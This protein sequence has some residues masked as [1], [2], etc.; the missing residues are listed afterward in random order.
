MNVGVSVMTHSGQS[1]WQSGIG[2]NALHLA[3]LLRSLPFVERVVFINVGD[4]PALPADALGVGADIPMLTQREATDLIDVA[5]ELAGGLD[6]EWID[7]L[8]ALG[9]KVVFCC[10]GQPYVALA[11]P[12]VFGMEGFFSRADRCDEVWL[13]P[14]DRALAPMMEALHRCRCVEVPFLW[15]PD[16]VEARICDRGTA[17]PRFGYAGNGVR[18]L[19]IMEPNISVLKCCSIPMLICD[20]AYR[21]AGDAALDTLH[22][23]NSEHMAQRPTF[24]YLHRSLDMTKRGKTR[25][26]HRHDVVG[27]MA[28]NAD[29]VVSHQWCNDQN[30]L[31]LDLLHGGYPL[32]HNSPWLRGLGY[33]YPEFDIEAGAHALLTAM[34]KHDGGLAA[35]RYAAAAFLSALHPLAAENR[36]AYARRL[37]ALDAAPAARWAA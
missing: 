30:Y 7:R 36:S 11:E 6:I 18:R 25:L 31:Y 13:L 29:A 2:Q 1:V 8:H 32:V 28:D 24:D 15:A 4:Q 5:I 19:A 23:L 20:Q 14:K 27:F 21:C 10:V 16:F 26:T 17:A 33:Y 34:R 12:T 22:V 3:V 37:L 35:Y 9:K